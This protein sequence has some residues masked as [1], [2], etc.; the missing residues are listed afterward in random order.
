MTEQS[1]ETFKKLIRV[2]EQIDY[3][4]LAKDDVEELYLVIRRKLRV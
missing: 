2:V 3:E 1:Y 4:Q